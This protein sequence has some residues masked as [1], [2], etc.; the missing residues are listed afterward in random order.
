MQL[1]YNGTDITSRAGLTACICREGFGSSGDMLEIE[2]ANIRDWYR[3]APQRDD[4]MEAVQ[5]TYRTGKMYL[6]TMQKDGERMRLI[7]TSMKSGA[8]APGERGLRA[9]KPC[10]PACPERG[11]MRHEKRGL[12]DGRGRCLSAHQTACAKRACVYGAAAF[13]RRRGV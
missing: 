10:G 2:T 8:G 13:L 5:G 7:A 6:N 11:G 3:W 4:E 1:F 9:D 12:R